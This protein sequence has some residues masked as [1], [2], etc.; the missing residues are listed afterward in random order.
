MNELENLEQR[1]WDRLAQAEQGR[2]L[3]SEHERWRQEGREQRTHLFHRVADR[4]LGQC[5]RPRL[6]RLAEH[7]GHAMPLGADETGRNRCVYPLRPTGRFPATGRL[8]VA[9]H[10][11]L[12]VEKVFLLFHFELLPAPVPF[13]GQ[14][15]LVFRLEEVDDQRVAA[16][17]E[18]KLLQVL[19]VYLRLQAGEQKTL[20]N[21]A[22]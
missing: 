21:S 22:A 18:D 4:L 15:R 7:L 12:D 3:A 9:V 5:I 11:D 14:D 6:E 20:A 13:E 16:W 10:H 8:E 2:R 1:I 17:I 19:D